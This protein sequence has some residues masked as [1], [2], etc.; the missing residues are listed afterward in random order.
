[1][2]KKKLCQRMVDELVAQVQRKKYEMH[3]QD[4]EREQQSMKDHNHIDNHKKNH[5]KLK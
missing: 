3:K 4:W 1:M 5:H 2:E